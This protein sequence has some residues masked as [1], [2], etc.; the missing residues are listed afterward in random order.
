MWPWEK[1]E[2][3]DNKPNCPQES[4]NTC[5]YTFMGSDEHTTETNKSK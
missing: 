1:Q 5:F 3:E 4:N 2:A